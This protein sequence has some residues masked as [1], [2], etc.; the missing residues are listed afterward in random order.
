MTTSSLPAF[1]GRLATYKAARLLRQLRFPPEGPPPWPGGRSLHGLIIG[2]TDDL[3]VDAGV[4]HLRHKAC[5]NP[6]DFVW[7]LDAA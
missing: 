2:H 3:V 1:S 6:L 7:P 4:Q 5:P